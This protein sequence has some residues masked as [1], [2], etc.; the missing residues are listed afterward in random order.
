MCSIDQKQIC[1][2]RVYGAGDAALCATHQTLCAVAHCSAC[3]FSVHSA[4][5]LLGAAVLQSLAGFQNLAQALY[6]AIN[7]VCTLMVLSGVQETQRCALLIKRH[8]L[9]PFAAPAGLAS[10]VQCCCLALLHCRALQASHNFALA[11][12]LLRELWPACDQVSEPSPLFMQR[13]L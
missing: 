10:T 9:S 12:T 11:P 2:R 5:L 6:Q 8:A 1:L 3:G 13:E 4:V 7:T